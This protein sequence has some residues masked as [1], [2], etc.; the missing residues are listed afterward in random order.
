MA[1][2]PCST[3]PEGLPKVN[4]DN[5]PKHN[6]SDDQAKG[7]VEPCQSNPVDPWCQGEDKYRRDQVTNESDADN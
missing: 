3:N 7:H 4:K 6:E 1:I 5:I 2:S